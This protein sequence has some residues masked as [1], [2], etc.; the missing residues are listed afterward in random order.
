[1]LKQKKRM[2]RSVFVAFMMVLVVVVGVAYAQTGFLVDHFDA[3]TQNLAVNS[4]G[5]TSANNAAGDT[6]TSILG[7]ERDA[8]LDFVSGSGAI[9]LDINA[10]G[11]N[12]LLYGALPLARGQAEV[13]WDGNDGDATALDPTG[14]ANEDLTDSSTKD[15]FHIRVEEADKDFDLDLTVYEDTDECS[16]YTISETDIISF[17]G[18]SYFVPFTDFTQGAGCGTGPAVFS[19]AGAVTLFIDGSAENGLD[20]VIEYVETNSRD[21][22]DLPDGT[23]GTPDYSSLTTLANDGA[24]H[25]LGHIKLGAAID[26]EADAQPSAT[27]NGDD[28][29]GVDDE[30]GVTP[31]GNWSD[32][33]GHVDVVVAGGSGCLSG[34]LDFWDGAT[35]GPDGNFASANETIITNQHVTVGTNTFN[36]TLPTDAADS[37]A[38]FARFRLV[39]DDDGDGSCSDQ[40]LIGLKGQVYDG[41]VE[42]YLFNFDPTAVTLSDISARPQTNS[43]LLVIAAGMLLMVAVGWTLRRVRVR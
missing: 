34:F 4:G 15:G 14:L 33:T 8:T 41:E 13:T 37:G 27:A 21:F 35:I 9:S 7:G 38:F 24:R 25:I 43:T 39:P 18:K 23:G 11:E 22:G 28:A 29:A 32:G 40:A 30:D 19:S 42:D 2:T 12:K 10:F 31:T 5:P 16:E 20:L 17:P 36:F 6:E 1:M 3:A 26:G